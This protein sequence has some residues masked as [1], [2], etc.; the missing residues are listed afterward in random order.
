MTSA[1]EAEGYPPRSRAW[2]S[3]VVIFLIT[4]IALADRMAIAMLIGPIKAEF[5]IGD[6]QA[7]LLV[8]LA[9]TLFYV[10]FL[11]PI[12]MAAD[13]F[14][15]AKVLGVCLAVWSL[16]TVL[17]GFATGFIALF[18]CRMLAGSGE[19]AIGPCS[20]GIIGASF[21]RQ[22]MAKPMA[23]QG[24]GFQAGPAIGVAAA[25][26]ILAAGSAGAFAGWPLLGD[27]A[28]WRVAFIL[29]G[30][31]GLLALLLVPLLHSPPPAPA[32]A[33][34]A[35]G[36][37]L[38]FV[39]AIRGDLTLF[40]LTAGCSAIATGVITA[41]VPEYLQR[42]L[43]AS[44]AEAGSALGLI[45]LAAAFVGQ[46]S[47]ATA[48]DWLAARGVSDAPLRA[49]LVPVA[50]AIPLGWLAFSAT[51]AAAFYPLLFGLALCTSSLN[52]AHNTVAQTIATPALRAR[53]GALFIFAI[54][55]IGFA[56]GPALVGALSE[57][58]LG[59]AE[60]GAAMRLVAVSSMALT[61]LLAL[62][63]RRAL[64]ARMA[65]QSQPTP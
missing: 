35:E 53:V 28:P 36:Q 26:A 6:F 20:Q 41:W 43:G 51:S 44:P 61:L 23:L 3:A 19:A 49:S 13:R 33:S 5:G 2:L 32:V 15:R 50:L 56:I 1:S 59:E 39:R 17:C 38:P 37:L 16:A 24:I 30:L 7:S 4:A 21:P 12:G 34:G 63:A 31:P 42:V 22:A 11:I 58:V 60:L 62:A 27:L 25:G 55:V 9:F 57:Y 47:L 10:L 46:G 45:L 40:L 64:A 29:I 54:N 18:I 52:T 65:A 14:S 48:I 8:G